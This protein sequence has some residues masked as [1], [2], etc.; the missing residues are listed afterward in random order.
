MPALLILDIIGLSLSIS[1]STALVLV[2][3]S[4]SIRRQINQSFMLFALAESGW[5]VCSLLLRIMLWIHARN[6]GL[7]LNLAALSFSLTTPFLLLF[8]ARYTKVKGRWP[9]VVSLGLLVPILGGVALLLENQLTHSPQLDSW[10]VLSYGFSPL[11]LSGCFVC[12]A[13]YLV[14]LLFLTVNR[15]E[16][17]D[18]RI[19]ASVVILLAGFI[20]GGILQLKGP[21]MAFAGT[22]S[23]GL[24]GWVIV[25]RQLFN[26]LR[27]LA[28]DLRDRAHRQELI[29]KVSRTT[30]TLLDIDELLGQAATL[31]QAS[32]GCFI[33]SVFLIEGDELV[34]RASSLPEGARYIKRMRLK[35]GREGICG[36]VA[37]QG[38]P[39][40]AGD[41]RADARYVEMDAEIRILSEM[42][43]P[44]LRSGRPIGVLDMQSLALNAFS[45]SDLRMQ[46]TIADQLSNAI[47]NARLYQETRRRAE[48]LAL[49]NRIS[50]VAGSVLV[51]DELLR[52]VHR[53]VTSLFEAEAFF[54]ALYDARTETLDFRMQIDA[55]EQSPPVT[56]PLGSGLTSQVV[57]T[58]QPLLVNDPARRAPAGT[59]PTTWGTGRLPT[60]WMGVPMFSG[61]RVIGVMSVQTYRDHRYDADDLLLAS[62]IAE[63]V[64]VAIENARLYEKVSRELEVRQR[65]EKVLR[66]SE[67][68]FRNLAEESPNIIFIYGRERVLYANRQCET[69]MGYPREELYRR[70][71]PFGSLLAPGYLS[72]ALQNYRRHLRRESVPPYEYI[73]V[74]RSGRRIDAIFTSTRI[75]YDGRPAILGIV[76]DITARKRTERLLQSLNAATLSMEQAL[77]PAEI[78]PSA[79]RVLS[80]LGFDS[81]VFML[82]A[83]RERTLRLHCRGS[84]LTGDILVF[85]P[86]DAHGQAYPFDVLPDIAQAMDGSGALF[87]MLEPDAVAAFFTDAPG[88]RGLGPHELPATPGARGPGPHELPPTEQ[89]ARLGVILAPL[90]VGDEQ[91]GLCVISGQD[92]G[93]EDLEI[94]TAFAHQAAAAWRKTRLMRDLEA[95]IQ[96]LRQ[97]QEQL[98]HSQKMEAIGRLAGGIAHDFNNL[99]TVISGYTTLLQEKVEDNTPA[100]EDITQIKNTIKRASS[101]TSRLLAFS[102]KQIIQ[103]TV[104]DINRLVGNAANLLRPIIGEDIEL[105]VRLSPAPLFVKADTAQMDQ[106]IMNLAVNARD[107]MPDGGALAL[108]TAGV[109]VD[110]SGRLSAPGSA[111]VPEMPLP[112]GLPAGTWVMLAVRDTGIGMSEETQARLFEPFFTTK[113]EGKGSGLGLSTVYAIVVQAGGRMHVASSLGAGSTFTVWLPGVATDDDHAAAEERPSE[114]PAGSGTIL[115]V[116]DET[117]VREL[118]RKVLE[119]QGYRVVAVASAREALLV[120]EGPATLDL[121]VTDVIMPGGMNGVEMGERLS[122]TRPSLPVLYMS[123]YT[124]DLRSPSLAHPSGLEFLDKPFQP[125]ELLARVK[126]LVKKG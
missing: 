52:I 99:L 29:A 126:E 14:A 18:L 4:A 28:A 67:E 7:A 37:A 64:A 65:T 32:F 6:P 60:S 10:G 30:A 101:L 9:L 41:V 79:A 78:F 120:A 88:A 122:R 27:E 40:V 70:D 94:F 97:T 81:A 34:L 91:F 77:T 87:T 104:L 118:A 38:A 49:M 62:T 86:S 73:L 26:P 36:W 15:R 20:L 54:V 56:E 16:G 113:E 1:L 17:T 106:V 115:L 46:E 11:G 100:R 47:D 5:A 3:G 57:R 125:K 114:I 105:V 80:A 103:P 71:F 13:G 84:G 95:S 112:A 74:T 109:T 92:L 89:I 116:E 82:D 117:D 68:K 53:E 98:L 39:L 107:A 124:G 61:E 123:G 45:E 108:R 66:E 85:E 42:A 102:R 76:T 48:R 119:R 33:V 55:G 44:I 31:I 12:I 83:H 2:V 50:S 58:R 110:E 19:T 21:I 90:V 35:V 93:P 75:R 8:C 96:Q 72:I 23:V 59:R 51:L 24:M 121:V 63:Q 22:L 25:R 69:S 43:V 111:A